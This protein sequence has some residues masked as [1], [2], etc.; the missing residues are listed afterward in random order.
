MS[1]SKMALTRSGSD[2][3][4]WQ[5]SSLGSLWTSAVTVEVGRLAASRSA[6]SSM[7]GASGTAGQELTRWR[8]RRVRRSSGIG[9]EERLAVLKYTETISVVAAT[10]PDST[11][12]IR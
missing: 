1:Q 8:S 12:R 9:R 7:R 5:L 2:G 6:T 11:L 3:S 4:N 10:T